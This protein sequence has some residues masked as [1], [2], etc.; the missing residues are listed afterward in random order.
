MVEARLGESSLSTEKIA[1]EVG[2]PNL[3][4]EKLD[5]D[6]KMLARIAADTKG[7]YFHITTADLLLSQLDRSQRKRSQYVEHPLYSA[8]AF[9]DTIRRRSNN[10]MGVEKEISTT[11]KINV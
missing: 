10:G 9:L 6:E 7:R 5:L 8:A 2:R 1:F 4:F 3:E 11:V